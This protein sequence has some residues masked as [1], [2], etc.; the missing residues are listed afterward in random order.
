MDYKYI[1]CSLV[2]TLIVWKSTRTWPS[3][4]ELNS[5]PLCSYDLILSYLSNLYYT[6]LSP[7]LCQIETKNEWEGTA[8]KLTSSLQPFTLAQLLYLEL[9]FSSNISNSAFS[10]VFAISDSNVKTTPTPTFCWHFNNLNLHQ[11]W[12]F[13]NIGALTQLWLFDHFWI[14]YHFNNLEL[15]PCFNQI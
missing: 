2:C 8:H 1:N 13:D 11:V 14:S 7:T 4:P 12:S 9:R 15:L 3:Q 6:P 10:D 5:M